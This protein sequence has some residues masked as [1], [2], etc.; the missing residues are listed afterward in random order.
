AAAGSGGR[1][2]RKQHLRGP[3]TA[4]RRALRTIE[5]PRAVGTD[6]GGGRELTPQGQQDPQRI[7]EQVATVKNACFMLGFSQI[8]K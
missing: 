1:D 6:Q 7:A 2:R 5:E 3:G 4:T 8:L